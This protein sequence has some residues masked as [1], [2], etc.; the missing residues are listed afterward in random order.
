MICESQK[1]SREKY[2]LSCNKL[3]LAAGPWTPTYSKQ[4]FPDSVL[5]LQPT[6]D[7]G[8]W[9]LMENS[10]VQTSKTIAC[11]F[12]DDIVGE[13][14][15]YAGRNDETIWV[16]GQ[17]NHT[18][19]LLPPEAEH[20]PD[21][22]LISR[23]MKYSQ[24]FIHFSEDV[25]AVKSSTMQIL[26]TGR[27]FRAS[28]ASGLPFITGVPVG[29]LSPLKHG[30]E[31]GVFICYGHGSYGMSL[32]MGSGKLMAQV[33]QGVEP[34]IDIAKFTQFEDLSLESFYCV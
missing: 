25:D 7:A 30:K 23:L 8:D 27:A 18:E 10:N 1:D 33:I 4:L 20:E 5:N 21:E 32:G 16:C 24:G 9:V 12:F 13:K 17:R 6:I 11:V 3:V 28:T 31:T 19:K 22:G 15:Y 2:S 29:R 14:L 34:D 26:E